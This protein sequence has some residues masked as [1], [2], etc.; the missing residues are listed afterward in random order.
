MLSFLSPTTGPLRPTLPVLG[1]LFL[2]TPLLAQTQATYYVSPTSSDSNDGLS[3]TTPFATLT[4]ARDVVRVVKGTMSGNIIV[5]VMAGDY[6]VPSTIAFTDL[7]SGNGG[8]N[9]IYKNYN[10]TGSARFLGGTKVTGWSLYSG[11]IYRANIGTGLGIYTLY[12][13]GIRADMARYPKH[14]TARAVARGGYMTYTATPSGTQFTVLDNANYSPSGVAWNPSGKTFTNAWVYG[15]VGPDFHRWTSGTTKMV[16]ASGSDIFTT[17]SGGL[18][19]PWDHLLVEHSLELLE[20][21]G[22]YYYDNVTGYLYYYSRAN[23]PIASQEIIAPKIV[24]IIGVVGSSTSALAQNIQFVGLTFM[25]TDRVPQSQ[26]SDW[27]ETLPASYEAA[28]YIGNAQNIMVQNCRIASTGVSAI[29]LAGTTTTCTVTGCLIEHIG[30]NG[31]LT[32]TPS[33]GSLIS[34]SVIRYTGEMRGHGRGVSLE[35]GPTEGAIASHLDISYT[36][37]AALAISSG[38]NTVEYVK[39]HDCV[40]D[41]GDQGAFYV[42]TSPTTPT[43]ILNQCMA[44]RTYSDY[45]NWDRGPTGFYND[46]EAAGTS[47][48]NCDAGDRV[49][50]GAGDHQWWSFRHDTQVDTTPMQFTNCSWAITYAAAAQYSRTPNP[51]FN[52]A[53]MLTSQIGITSTFPAEYND[54]AAKPPTPIGL[55]ISQGNA[56]AML[57]WTQADRATSYAIKRATV[58]G[59]P[60]TTVGWVAV[61]PTGYDLGTQ[62]L[63]AGLANGTTYYYVI[64]ASN[65]AGE[66]SPSVELSVTPATTGSGALL[67]GTVIG[68]VASPAN[69]FDGDVNTTTGSSGW[70]GLDLGSAKVITSLEYTPTS[71]DGG[72]LMNGGVFEG[73]ND[74]A[75][76][77]PVTLF[78]IVATK[79]GALTSMR[80]PQAVYNTTPFRYVRFYKASGD[81]TVA[82]LRFFGQG[83]GGLPSPW[84]TQD[85]GAVAATGSVSYSSNLFAVVGSGADIWGTADEFRYVYKQVTGDCDIRARVT[86][87]QNVHTNAKAGVMIRE[88]LNANSTH[89]LLNVT[90][91]AG[92]EFIRRFTTGGTTSAQATAGVTA[93]RWVRMVRVGNNFTGYTSTDGATWT[94]VG[95]TQTITMAASVYVGL[96]VNSHLDG[97]LATGA[98]TNVAIASSGLLGNWQFDATSGTTAADSAGTNPGT[99]SATGATWTAGHL[100]NCVSLASASSGY[101]ALPIG[102]VISTLGDFTITAW[103]NLSTVTTWN[104]IFD[105]GSGTANYMFLTPKGS[106]NVIR[107]AITNSGGASEQQINGTAALPT[108]GWH[109]VTVTLAGA[110]GTLYVD[111]VAVGTNSSMTL[112][113][114]NLGTP[115]QNWIGRSQFSGDPYLNGSVDEFRIYGRA[116]TVAEIV[117]LP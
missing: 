60:Y 16:S 4:K 84:L 20:W 22:E 93:P 104:R 94:Q 46:R 61:P 9:V 44:S 41:S 83:G 86:S 54:L 8:F 72:S 57:R 98:F 14:A 114:S 108:G 32:L 74:A 56:E 110:V 31:V 17:S 109:R 113:P 33:T 49:A 58:S 40:Q 73:A 10:A 29:T 2:V 39:A 15:W 63:N 90:P 62:F 75:F 81:C 52:P 117:A 35:G 42:I 79:L 64:T 21:P 102:N 106:T 70:V 26:A 111:G 1:L 38:G 112:H 91:A 45:A 100:N 47:Y 37:R 18:G 23:G 115:T 107:F 92:A 55:W 7:D 67:S 13:N 43:N 53:G 30:Y 66:S 68:T 34:N 88:S 87:L 48:S 105:F 59:G 5:N 116:L 99:L 76:A 95:T 77:S 6:I 78:S 27:A 24:R 3:T 71:M 12:E 101:V 28:V 51:S 103:V 89:A 69:A 11:K 65:S 50:T 97:T 80:I 36:A 85:I 19:F 96:A 25:G 82:D